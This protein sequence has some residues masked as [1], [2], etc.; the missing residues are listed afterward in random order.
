MPPF[1]EDDNRKNVDVHHDDEDDN[2]NGDHKGAVEAIVGESDGADCYLS[3]GGRNDR[4]RERRANC[5]L[6]LFANR[7]FRYVVAV[8]V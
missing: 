1:P 5:Y 3:L 7:T 6:A 4:R 8:M 2:N